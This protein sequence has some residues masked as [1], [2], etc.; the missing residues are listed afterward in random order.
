MHAIKNSAL[1]ATVFVLG[2]PVF[3]ADPVADEV[4]QQV[5]EKYKTMETYKAEGTILM[6]A[7]TSGRK[8]QL[9]TSFTILLKKPD[10][11]LITW[12]QTGIV[13][14]SGAAWSD[15]TQ[16]YLYMGATNAYAKK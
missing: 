4:L 9:E 8:V 3:G 11:Y 2:M 13:P 7:E 6:D 5:S 12:K 16:P 10:L 1:A 15:G 14:Q